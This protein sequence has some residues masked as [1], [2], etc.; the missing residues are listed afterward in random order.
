MA[1][2]NRDGREQYDHARDARIDK[3]PLV[4]ETSR[5]KAVRIDQ[6]EDSMSLTRKGEFEDSARA[7][8]AYALKLQRRRSNRNKT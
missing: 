1:D 3:P 4:E 6:P 5:M 2:R 8:D 7:R